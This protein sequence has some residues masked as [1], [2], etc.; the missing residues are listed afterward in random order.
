MVFHG[1]NTLDEFETNQIRKIKKHIKKH[2]SIEEPPNFTDR[3][4]L[5]FL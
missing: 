1:W 2:V 3:D 4:Y 5:K